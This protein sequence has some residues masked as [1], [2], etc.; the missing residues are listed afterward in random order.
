MQKS[1]EDKRQIIE[2]RKLTDVELLREAN[3]FTT[4][5]DSRMSLATAY[6]LGHSTIRTQIFVVKMRNIP[7]FVASQLV[8]STQGVTWFMRSK[9][10]DRGGADFSAVCNS[11]AQ[12]VRELIQRGDEEWAEVTAEMVEELSRHFDRYTP[13]DLMCVINAEALINMAHKRLCSKASMETMAVVGT[14]KAEVSKVDP[15][16]ANHMVP[17]CIYRGGICPEAK[18]CGIHLN[19]RRINDYK[20]LFE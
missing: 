8:R 5:K 17:Q 6:R 18:P 12:N 7:L 15:D 14:I 10:V 11:L 20:A 16:L 2:V 9:R 19:Q 4:G 1:N 3:S 13:T